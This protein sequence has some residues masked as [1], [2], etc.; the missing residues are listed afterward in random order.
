MKPKSIIIFSLC[1]FVFSIFVFLFF[2]KDP[3]MNDPLIV[4]LTRQLESEGFELVTVGSSL[5]GRYRIEARSD[6]FE[7]EMVVAPGT[8]TILRDELS[9]LTRD[10]LDG[11]D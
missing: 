4:T 1:F 2:V 9:P 7:R 3:D 8:G 5:L 6:K 11:D 10:E